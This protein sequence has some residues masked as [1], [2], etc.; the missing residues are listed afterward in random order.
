MLSDLQQPMTDSVI[1]NL[2]PYHRTRSHRVSSS[3]DSSDRRITAHEVHKGGDVVRLEF[4]IS[5]SC[6]DVT[7]VMVVW[8]GKIEI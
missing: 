6:Q 3:T 2:V 4:D 1:K 7:V 5:V 8:K